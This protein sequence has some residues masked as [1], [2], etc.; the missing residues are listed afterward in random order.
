MATVDGF[1]SQHDVVRHVKAGDLKKE[2]IVD[3]FGLGDFG[4]DDCSFLAISSDWIDIPDDHDLVQSELVLL[5]KKMKNK[6]T[7]TKINNKIHRIPLSIEVNEIIY[8]PPVRDSNNKKKKRRKRCKKNQLLIVGQPVLEVEII[9]GVSIQSAVPVLEMEYG[10]DITI[11]SLS[12][13]SGV[14]GDQQHI[15]SSG[16]VYFK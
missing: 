2:K 7:A 4:S 10:T 5:K 6:N 15:F 1:V 13:S 14:T 11:P 8:I 12:L 3:D 9:N 16:S